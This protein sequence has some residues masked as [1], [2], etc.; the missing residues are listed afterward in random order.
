MHEFLTIFRRFLVIVGSVL[1]RWPS[2]TMLIFIMLFTPLLGHF[3]EDSEMY[4]E[5]TRLNYG[6]IFTPVRLVTL[7]SDVWSHVF[8]LQLPDIPVVDH[9]LNLPHC[10]NATTQQ[11]CEPNHVIL[12]LHK[13]HVDMERQI[14][15]ALQHV[16]HLL[17]D[18]KPLSRGFGRKRS[19]LPIGGHLLHQLF[20]TTTD[21]DLKPI[22]EHISRIAKGISHL[23]HGLQLQQHQFASF[24]EISVDRMDA[25]SNL[26]LIHEHAL[27]ELREKLRKLYQTEGQDQRRLVTA[28]SHLQ[29]YVN[30]LRHVDEFR[31]SIELLLQGILTPQLVSKVTLRTTLRRIK[32]ETQR[33]SP[34]SHLIFERATDFYAMRNFRFGRHDNHLLILLR[35]PITLFPYQFQIF[36]VT[37]FP[38]YVTGQASHTTFV[39]NLPPYFVINRNHAQYFTLNEID[40]DITEARLLHI[41]NKQITLRDVQTSTSCVNALFSNDISQ[42]YQLCAFTLK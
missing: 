2:G 24:V 29:Q 22:T 33:H 32:F 11:T 15:L 3:V 23:G 9:E 18:V 12:E 28:I 42:I 30:H 16:Y 40:D 27:G 17:P 13:Q 10:D 34:R 1:S 19:I 14:K 7:V 35:V 39:Q 21:D 31:H 4:N 38:V 5:V 25:F 41:V 6:V 26:S 8:D 36:K 20:G 37:L